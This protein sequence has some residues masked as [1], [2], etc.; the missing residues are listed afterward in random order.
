MGAYVARQTVKLLINAERSVKRA[1][2]GVLG[3]T[4]KEDVTDTRNSR[5]PD[6]LRELKEFGITALVHDP[7]AS[8]DEVSAEYGVTL[9]DL[10]SFTDLDGLIVA[11]SH[12]EYIEMGIERIQ[13]MITPGGVLVD[14]KSLFSPNEIGN[15]LIYWSL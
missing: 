6:I 5:V 7:K 12:K 9:S 15:D 2:L 11:V 3:V 13:E 10:D 14:V 8:K 1:K 4:F